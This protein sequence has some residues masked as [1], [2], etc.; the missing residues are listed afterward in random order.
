MRVPHCFIL[1]FVMFLSLGSTAAPVL[2]AVKDYPLPGKATRWDYMSVDASSS[3]LFIAHLGDS[4]VVVF[5]TT[6]KAFNGVIKDIGSAHGIVAVPELN[7]IYASATKTNEVVAIDT[8]TLKII[9]S[10]PTGFYPDGM[11]YAS[12]AHKLYVSNQFG[13]SETVID[14]QTNIPVAT[15]KMSGNVGNTQYDSVSKHIFVNVQGTSELVEI[16]PNTDRIVA[17]I[18]LADADSNHGLLIDA[19]HRLAFIAC[20]DNDKLL[21]VDLETKELVATFQVEKGPDVLAYDN[22]LGLLYVGSE[23]GKVSIFKVDQSGTVTKAA[24]QFVGPNAHTLAVDPTTHD[25]YFPLNIDG[26]PLLRAMR[27]PQGL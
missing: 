7:R 23:S 13:K 14:V 24:D 18:K 22:K 5:N 21:V 16:D 4:S 20:E 9:A 27:P 1:T 2:S 17:R 10:A 25:V 12:E 19:V 6:T 26:K 8:K 3:Q 15:I 11:A